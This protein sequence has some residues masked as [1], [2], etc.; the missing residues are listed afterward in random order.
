[1]AVIARV[2]IALVFLSPQLS[3]VSSTLNTS[4]TLCSYKHCRAYINTT[5]RRIHIRSAYVYTSSITSSLAVA[6]IA[7]RTAYDV[8]SGTV[9]MSILLIYS[10]QL[11]S[12]L[13]GCQLLADRC[14]LWLNDSL[15]PTAKVSEEV[16]MKCPS[17]QYNFQPYTDVS[18]TKSPQCTASQTH[19]EIDRRCQ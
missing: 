5:C 16:N 12:A 8:L 18:A 19:R 3:T 14:V 15:H 1:M 2:S 11:K 17:R 4:T 10:Y 9:V 7:D 6:V 13:D